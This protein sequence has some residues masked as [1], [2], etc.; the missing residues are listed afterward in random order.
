LK[1]LIILVLLVIVISL[2]QALYY[3]IHDRNRSPRTV[4]ALTLRIGL[5][6][7]LFL[8]LMAGF[9]LGLIKPHGLRPTAPA[10]TPSQAR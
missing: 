1:A 4:R 2:G 9:G 7:G 5:S 10:E 8:L 3:L 6:L